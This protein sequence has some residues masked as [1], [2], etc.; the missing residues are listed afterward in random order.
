M[1]WN[2]HR[3]NSSPLQSFFIRL[4]ANGEDAGKASR[5]L[6]Y[7]YPMVMSAA[8]V[9]WVLFD[10]TVL[11]IAP[12]LMLA[13][14]LVS[15]LFVLWRQDVNRMR[16]ERMLN[17]A[18]E[19]IG[20]MGVS[21]SQYGS[22]DLAVR[23]AA[24]DGD[25][26]LHRMLREAAWDVDKR[27][28]SDMK[29]ALIGCSRGLPPSLSPVRR[30]LNLL[31]AACEV[32][33]GERQRMVDDANESVTT[34]LKELGEVYC[35]SLNVPAMVI[36]SLVV[37]VP[38]IAM[39]LLP[40]LS[41]SGAG[42]SAIMGM[43]L[44]VLI[45]VAVPSLATVYL[46]HLIRSNPFREMAQKQDMRPFLCLLATPLL[47]FVIYLVTG[48]A[49]LTLLGAFALPGALAYLASHPSEREFKSRETTVVCLRESFMEMGNRLLSGEPLFSAMEQTL[50]DRA[51][52][53][54]VWW[55]VSNKLRLGR[56]DETAVLQNAIAPFSISLSS[57]YAAVSRAA[58]RDPRAA[59]RLC[60]NLGRLLQSQASVRKNIQNQLRSMMDMMNGTAAVFAPLILGI[61][62]A[63]ML[64]IMP[65]GNG[66][67]G[68][69]TLMLGIY[70]VQLC[71]IS[72]FMTTYLMGKGGAGTAMRKFTALLPVAISVFLL[73]SGWGG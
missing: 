55:Q 60:I 5:M 68:S 46:L 2:D 57:A 12:A 38:V 31:M 44:P 10:G 16:P 20:T 23:S 65:A 6:L 1:P 28:F 15:S 7:G 63:M 4:G 19:I 8:L 52:G 50:P 56:E 40:L 18:P 36:F 48:D 26:H 66:N 30:S 39:S 43:V 64:P 54:G 32:E 59:G 41:F 21:I 11:I 58:E 17:Q 22:L 42:G 61:S 3:G 62:S 24:G 37:M 69:L 25:S 47:A 33:G 71:L 70:L 13:P 49:P 51:E 9:T 73:T 67:D 14:L 45:L 72:A 27:S 35:S 34:G 29:E 53:Q